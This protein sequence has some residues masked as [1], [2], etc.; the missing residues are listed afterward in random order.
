MHHHTGKSRRAA[1]SAAVALAS[2][3]CWQA[4]ACRRC[5]PGRSTSLSATTPTPA[6]SLRQA[7]LDLNTSGGATNNIII[8]SGVGTITLTSGDLQTVAKNVAIVGNNNTLSRQQ[9]V[10]RPVHRRLLGHDPDGGRGLD[11]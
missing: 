9:P 2:S 11:L 8:N 4:P 5:L 1:H 7:I 3:P 6:G 10:P